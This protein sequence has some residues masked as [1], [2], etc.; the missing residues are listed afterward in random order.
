MPLTK[1]EARLEV[2]KLAVRPGLE[3]A[4]I[5]DTADGYYRFITMDDAQPEE[6]AEPK[7]PKR[8]NTRQP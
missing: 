7:P 1:A 2:L 8:A 5:L 3:F 6:P 4:A